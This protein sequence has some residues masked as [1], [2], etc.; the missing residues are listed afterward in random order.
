MTKEQM[1]QIVSEN[2]KK[3]YLYCVRRLGN[4]SDAEDVASDIMLEL[5]RSYS[6]VRDDAAVHSYMWSVAGNLCKRFWRK[7]GKMATMEIPED[8]AGT[9]MITPEEQLIHEEELLTLRRE[10]SLLS[11]KYRK[12]MIAHYIQQKTCE[13]IAGE[14]G[15][16]V[17]NVKQYLFEGRKK[18]RKG[19]DMQREYGVYSY[20]PEKFTMDFWGDSGESYWSLFDRKL[21]GSIMLSVYDAPKTLEELSMEVGVSMPYLEEEVARL[22]E[23]ELL[24]KQGNKYRSGIVIYDNAFLDAVKRAAREAL[25]EN[26]EAIRAMVKR[27]T[28]LLK[29]TD[30][31]CYKDDENVRGWFVLMLI[32]WE[33][34]QQSESK[35]K[36]PLTF[37]LLAN[38]SRGYVMGQ[39]GEHEREVSGFYGM[40]TLNHGY[41][42][43]LNFN[44]LTDRVVNPF[45]MG[46][47]DVLLACEERRGETSEWENLSDMIEKKIVH[48]E[49]GKIC[50]NYCEISETCSKEIMDKMAGEIDFMADLS[51]RLREHAAK[52]LAASTPKDILHAEEIGSI[53]SMWKILENMVP[54]A[55]E[56]GLLTKGTEEQNLTVFYIHW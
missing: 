31:T 40:Y 44:R 46:V 50:P 22:L 39:R 5:L 11:E 41:L 4:A 37:P 26:I 15:L 38:G 13:E 51:A 47:R 19:M 54:I 48:I 29:E 52:T 21:P 2:M 23:Y 43:S 3:I 7:A 16:T 24:V 33:A 27:G 6:E 20:A 49:D 56:S 8:Y 42:R 18:V 1:E 17:T 32:L 14:M 36:T 9:Y 25:T 45:E 35:L 53:L 28:E 10:L 30:F 12:V 34:V 55:L